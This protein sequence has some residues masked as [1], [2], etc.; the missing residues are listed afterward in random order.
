MVIFSALAVKMPGAVMAI[1]A[2]V[3]TVDY[4]FQYRQWYAQH[5]VSMRELKEKFCQ[6]TA[7]RPSKASSGNCAAVPKGG[8]VVITNPIHFAIAP[9]YERHER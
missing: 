5:K 7:I 4:L 6:L 3:A 9:R 1:L 2:I 8:L